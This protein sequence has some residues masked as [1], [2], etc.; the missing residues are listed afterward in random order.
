MCLKDKALKIM[1][2]SEQRYA[3]QWTKLKAFVTIWDYYV[4]MLVWVLSTPRG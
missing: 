2:M 1:P 3:A 4:A